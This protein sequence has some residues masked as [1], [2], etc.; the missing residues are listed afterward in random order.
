[1]FGCELPVVAYKNQS[2]VSLPELVVEGYTGKVFTTPEELSSCL[3]KW[4][5]DFLSDQYNERQNE[6]KD[7][8]K[9]LFKNENWEIH[10]KKIARPYFNESVIFN[11][12]YLIPYVLISICIFSVI[13][14]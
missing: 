10:W 2:F 11:A 1:M 6:F 9:R 8:I 12:K 4:F 5:N 7:N 3:K 13:W 14:L